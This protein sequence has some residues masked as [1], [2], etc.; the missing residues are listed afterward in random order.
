MFNIDRP[1]SGPMV[2]LVALCTMIGSTASASILGTG[3]DFN[4]FIFGD[5]QYANTDFEGRVAAGG[6]VTFNNIG[7]GNQLPNSNGM[8]DDLIV[9]GDINWT[10]GQVF[11]GN[12]VHGGS[13]SLTGV[14]FPGGS[15]I[16]ASPIDFS[17]VQSE[18]QTASDFWSNLSDTGTVA[19]QFGQL[20][21]SG[22]SSGLNVFTVDAADLASANGLNMN[23]PSG[24]SVL[25]NVTGSSAT[26][27]NF[28]FLGSWDP[29]RTLFN[30]VDATSLT[31]SGIGVQGSILAPYADVLFQNGQMDGTLIANSLQGSGEFHHYIFDGDLPQ[32]PTSGAIALFGLAALGAGRRRRVSVQI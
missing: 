15:T 14:G 32:V 27:Q 26:L 22:N 9:G 3:G 31:M 13:A 24:S 4:A 8:R 11:G 2:G 28:G 10:N 20:N 23:A 29:N 21:F 12:L 7:I 5:I 6:N 25:I 18:A 1:F 17:V 30:F 16:Q 19:N